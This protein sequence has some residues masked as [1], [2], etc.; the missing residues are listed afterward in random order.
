MKI[1][2]TGAEG[3]IGSHLLD[4]LS[5]IKNINIDCS[6][7]H[8]TNN[9][10]GNINTNLLKKKNIKFFFCDLTDSGFV[11]N[12]IN[13]N[14]YDYILNLASLISVP[15]SFDLPNTFFKNNIEIAHNLL[16][17]CRSSK[18]IKKIFFFS[19][20][21]VYGSA[22]NLPITEKHPLQ[23]QSPYAASKI[24]VDSLVLSYW[25][26]YKLPVTIIRPFNCYGPKQSQRAVIPAIINQ[27]LSKKK[28]IKLGT[29]S[30]FRDYTL[31]YD[32]VK[33]IEK[34]L[35]METKLSGEVINIGTSKYFQIK[36]IVSLVS[37]ITKKNKRI[38]LDKQRKRPNKSE[39]DR[40]LCDNTKLLKIIG[41]YK[42]TSFVVG[43]KQTIN[44][45]KKILKSNNDNYHK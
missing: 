44:Y 33:I 20:S 37:K 19:S 34:L 7:L 11:N 13:K 45:Q 21:E 30:T 42:F 22:K 15:L 43:L 39:I 10:Y 36:D 40:L 17:S 35:F 5:K 6:I 18:N 23:P 3:F 9:S 1:L 41:N 26:S 29:T 4:K 31:V 14:K 24:A 2:L 8:N 38:I 32:L 12:L 27:F 16:N 28:L 25:Y